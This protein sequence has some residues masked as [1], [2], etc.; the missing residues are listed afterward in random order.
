ML[1]GRH[2]SGQ[3][4]ILVIRSIEGSINDG[5]N[6]MTPARTFLRHLRSV[7]V[8]WLTSKT[9]VSYR[10]ENEEWKSNFRI[11]DDSCVIC[12]DAAK[13]HIC[14]PCGHKCLCADCAHP[15]DVEPLKQCPMCRADIVEMTNDPEKV[16][17]VYTP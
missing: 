4:Q 9:Y 7:S 15:S 5:E 6:E 2:T 3:H 17:K 12:I 11:N 14:V 13:T 1:L 10:L 8:H 16:Q